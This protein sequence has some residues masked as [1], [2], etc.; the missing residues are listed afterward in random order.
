M[1]KKIGIFVGILLFLFLGV[2]LVLPSTYRVERSITINKPVAMVYEQ[3]ADLNNFHAWNAWSPQEPTAKF[4]IEGTQKNAG[5]SFSWEGKIIGVGRFVISNVEENS[6]IDF[7]L[8]FKE[9][10]ESSSKE[11]F[12]FVPEGNTTKVMWEDIGE[13]TYPVGR[14]MGLMMDKMLGKDFEQGLKNLKER[15]EKM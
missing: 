5:A 14:Y 15:V 12:I 13:A 1:L 6:Q 4:T 3:V 8:S 2:A 10:F 9:P 7:A 11:K